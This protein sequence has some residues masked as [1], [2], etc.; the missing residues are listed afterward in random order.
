MIRG[1]PVGS[2]I[3]DSGSVTSAIG[4]RRMPFPDLCVFP[5]SSLHGVSGGVGYPVPLMHASP[6]SQNPVTS[7][8]GA[9]PDAVSCGLAG[10]AR[11]GLFQGWYW[12]KDSADN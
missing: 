3:V 1:N 4:T 2:P 5:T 9:G 6:A 7:R 12:Q 10:H 11:P 8:R